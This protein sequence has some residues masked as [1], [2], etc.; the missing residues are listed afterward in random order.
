MTGGSI[1]QALVKR[2]DNILIQISCA[3]EQIEN[4]SF[5]HRNKETGFAIWAT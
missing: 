3:L 2:R 5:I 4:G 1:Y